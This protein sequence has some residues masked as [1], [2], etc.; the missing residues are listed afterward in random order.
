MKKTDQVVIISNSRCGSTYLLTALNKYQDVAAD[1]ELKLPPTN[2]ELLDIH[3]PL[4]A[5]KCLGLQELFESKDEKCYI[6]K[7]VLDP[8][9]YDHQAINILS[10]SLR[11]INKFIYIRRPLV[12]QVLSSLKSGYTN[13][14]NKNED[15]SFNNKMLFQLGIQSLKNPTI[16]EIELSSDMLEYT[17][18]STLIRLRNEELII[19]F[20]AEEKKQVLQLKYTN[21]DFNNESLEKF[22]GIHMKIPL[23][24]LAATKKLVK[25]YTKEEL[26]LFEMFGG[27]DNYLEEKVKRSLVPVH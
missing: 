8:I 19:R 11:N 4:S 12:E 9:S 16:K 25:N 26:L 17:L 10:K 13:V 3:V 22:L 1:Y 7:L 6:S 27:L 23:S 21:S 5:D 14:L 15:L 2:Y 20:L 24:E 18:N